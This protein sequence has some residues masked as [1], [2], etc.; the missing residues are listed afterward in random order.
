LFP[1]RRVTASSPDGAMAGAKP[2]SVSASSTM[3]C[4]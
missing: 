1:L 3:V 2:P 4:I